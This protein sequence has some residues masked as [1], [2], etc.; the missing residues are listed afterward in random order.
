MKY[1]KKTTRTFLLV[2]LVLFYLIACSANQKKPPTVS[3][4]II[5]LSNWNFAS[6][7]NVA[8]DGKWEFYWEKLLFPS[9][10]Q[11][12][13]IDRKY[14]SVPAFW[15][16]QKMDKPL[17]AF[18]Y[19]TYRL[20][21]K[22][23][24]EYNSYAIK[25]PYILSSWKLFINGELKQEV[26]TVSKSQETYEPGW[27]PSIVIQSQTAETME[28]ILQ[29]ANY[30]DRAG[31]MYKSIKIGTSKE[32]LNSHI[33]NI[34]IDLMLFGMIIIIGIYHLIIFLFRRKEIA[35]VIFG[36]FCFAVGLRSIFIGH[37]AGLAFFDFDYRTIL[38]FSYFN[39]YLLISLFTLFLYSLYPREINKYA[40]YASCSVGG[41]A[42]VLTLLLPV[43]VFSNLFP[44]FELFILV[45]FVYILYVLILSTRNNREGALYLLIATS[46]LFLTA[47]TDMLSDANIINL[48]LIF[49]AGILVLLL[50][51]SIILALRYSNTHKRIIALSND[52][53]LT[54]RNLEEKNQEL[55]ELNKSLEDKVELRAKNL[56]ESDEK[57][58]TLVNQTND[59]IIIVQDGLLK[60]VN[61]AFLEMTNYLEE[62]IIDRNFLK[63]F[64]IDEVLKIG[65]VYKQVMEGINVSISHKSLLKTAQEDYLNVILKGRKITYDNK[66]STLILF[67]DITAEKNAYKKLKQNEKRFTKFL[68]KIPDGIL[69]VRDYKI[70][71]ANTGI[72]KMLDLPTEE[73]IGAKFFDYFPQEDFR[74]IFDNL[75]ESEADDEN[76][77]DKNT[78]SFQTELDL[79]FKQKPISIDVISE[80]IEYKGKKACIILIKDISSPKKQEA[81]F[82][83]KNS[84]FMA[85]LS[86]EVRTPLNVVLNFINLML[87][88]FYNKNTDGTFTELNETQKMKLEIIY[89]NAN[90]ILSLFTKF[91]IYS[92]LQT[93]KSQLNYEKFYIKDELDNF[94]KSLLETYLAEKKYKV[95]ANIDYKSNPLINCDKQKF[96]QIVSNLLSNAAKYTSEGKITV[97]VDEI[98][99][100]RIQIIVEDTGTGIP[101]DKLDS[102]FNE[103]EQLSNR[104][105]TKYVG[106]GLG[107]S[108]VKQ[109]VNLLN[110]KITVSSEPGKGSTFSVILPI[111]KISE[112]VDER[113][114]SASKKSI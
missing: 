48:P 27:Q 109:L 84:Q 1:I 28:I 69:I 73:L 88:G 66:I 22:T 93:E 113:E 105:N 72:S 94:S 24:P 49:P 25:L 100:N 59:G 39:F 99:D 97:I 36:I 16:A 54:A 50:M 80:I 78:I 4:G 60:Y 68:D 67:K 98:S 47:I 46:V 108:I 83:R 29:I 42:A 91:L 85:N 31:G 74:K 96:I 32:I 82:Q 35:N 10:F 104:S 81:E 65:T 75:K 110:G 114:T 6:N 90:Y 13:Q 8:L 63:L 56:L 38:I 12:R 92:K 7:G 71:F 111:D 103:F 86:H 89:D 26:G 62:S 106:T 51:K 23:N 14:I 20:N 112:T 3:N 79:K 30:S 44:Y 33:F 18:G 70:K 19:A 34:G 41:I 45:N 76:F 21:I 52:L 57:Y 11:G 58:Q 87:K 9:D 17:P 77:L 5:D 37:T 53:S 2:I 64:P 43:S 55:E 107:L 95:K 101:S 40:L 102:I 15:N 61:R